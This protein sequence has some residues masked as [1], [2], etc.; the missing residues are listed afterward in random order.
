MS[1]SGLGWLACQIEPT[2]NTEAEAVGSAANMVTRREA[3]LSK[4][5]HITVRASRGTEWRLIAR[6]PE[7]TPLSGPVGTADRAG[8]YAAYSNYVLTT[9]Y[10]GLM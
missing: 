8:P 7:Q 6:P 10:P 2:L 1:Q 9:G 3:V 4:Y 5:E